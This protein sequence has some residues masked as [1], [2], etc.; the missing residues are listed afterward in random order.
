MDRPSP[1]LISRPKLEGW[2]LASIGSLLLA[3]LIL[4]GWSAHEKRQRLAVADQ[5][6]A[7]A[8]LGTTSIVSRNL[9]FR[10]E[11]DSSISV[12]DADTGQRLDSIEGEAGFARS[13][14]RSLAR[15]RLK[16]GHGPERPFTLSR[17]EQGGLVL[18]DALTGERI[19]LA[20]LGP[21]NAGVF[22]MYLK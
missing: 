14:L 9:V 3:S 13:V 8:Y 11:P 17:T 19:D 15:A 4:A 12:R 16:A 22:A 20:A 21:T 10:D 18:S 1:R 5:L 7:P 6:S 2:P